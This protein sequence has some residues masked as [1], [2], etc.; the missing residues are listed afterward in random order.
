M[1]WTTPKTWVHGELVTAADLNTYIRDNQLYLRTMGL[2][3]G[4][5]R[6]IYCALG[7]ASNKNP[8][9]GTTV[10]D[11]WFLCDGGTYNGR[12]TPDLRDRFLVGAGNSYALGAT[13][14]SATVDISHTHGPGTL[15]TDTVASHAHALPDG[16]GSV[17][18]VS[19]GIGSA[20]VTTSGDHEHF[21]GGYT[22]GAGSHSHA[23][24]S[25]ETASGGGTVENRPP[26]YAVYYFM[27]CPA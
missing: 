18:K 9:V 24:A 1:G 6:A 15:A 23:V 21:L 22:V 12:A 19:S 20:G 26:Y 17:S 5:I 2:I 25:G 27:Y 3:P 13:G 16:T 4:E 7:G 10:Y 14:G 11:D 8:Q